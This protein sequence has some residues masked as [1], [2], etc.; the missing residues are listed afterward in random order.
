MDEVI[1]TAA[2]AR[3]LDHVRVRARAGRGDALAALDRLLTGTGHGPAEVIAA[4]L[5]RARI[6]LNFHPDRL[7]A[8]GRS[9]ARALAED[10]IYRSQFETGI[11]NGARTAY[12]GGGRDVWEES[13]FGGAYHSPEVTGADR[14]RYGGLDLLAH[15]DGA[16]PRFGSCYLRLRPH[17]LA[18]A[19]FCVGDSHLGPE[20]LGTADAAEAVLAA[21]LRTAADTG[22]AL[23]VAGLTVA[24][25]VARLHEPRPAAPHGAAARS[26]DDYLEVQVHGPVLLAR[27]VEA[28]VADPSFRDTPSGKHLAEL[29]D[30]HGVELHWHGG[31]RLP[32]DGVDADFRGPAIP[33]LARRV[34]REFAGPGA[35]VDA[36][37]VGLAAASATTE[38]GRWAD[39][40][41]QDETLQ[42]LKQL[43]H[44]LVRFGTPAAA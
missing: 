29:A 30:R 22:T 33:V 1:L 15:P 35:P 43:W 38:P 41:T 12:P 17:T 9:V 3:A 16:C 21:L 2:Q 14:P 26:L 4:A 24:D 8:D 37:L 28:V 31:F 18:R 20:H 32:V 10:G 40:G 23:G 25:L 11:S 13:L 34:H 19:T 39:H 7:A 6:T 5:G 27:D 36:A 42:H 44:V